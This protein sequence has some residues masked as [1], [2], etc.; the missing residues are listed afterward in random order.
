MISSPKAMIIIFWLPLGFPVIHAL[1]PKLTF[2]SKLFV[3]DILPHI[4]AP[5]QLEM[6]VDPWQVF[7]GISHKIEW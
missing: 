6:M 7:E 1:P 5:S 2:T 3:G 4:V